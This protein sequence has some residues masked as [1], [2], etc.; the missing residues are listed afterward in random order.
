LHFSPHI[1]D[2]WVSFAFN[3]RFRENQ[4]NIRV[5]KNSTIIHNLKGDNIELYIDGKLIEVLANSQR[6]IKI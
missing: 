1:P 5:E 4:L 2:K 3:I 6:E